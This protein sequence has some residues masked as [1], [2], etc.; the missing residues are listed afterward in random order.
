[1]K[2]GNFKM[3]LK[4][5]KEKGG[6]KMQLNEK[7]KDIQ[8][9]YSKQRGITLIALVV[10]IVVLLI[11]AGVSINAVFGQDGIIKRAKYAQ[12]KMDQATQNDLDSINELNNWI[13]GKIN[14]TTGGT[15]E[16]Q[17][18]SLLAMYQKAQ[19]DGCDNADGTCSDATHLHIG[20][21]VDYKNPT[22]GTAD[23]TS[24][25]SGVYGNDSNGNATVNITQTYTLS[26]TK[27]NVK[28]R[29]LGIDSETGGLKLIAADPIERDANSSLSVV[30]ETAGNDP[31]LYLKGAEA[32]WY[33]P[34]A[35]N[36]ISSMYLNSA[37]AT[38]SRSVTMDD[39]NE[40]TGVTE[41]K[42]AEV[43]VLHTMSGVQQY[44]TSFSF[45]K[46]QYTPKLWLEIGKKADATKAITVDG[47]GE[48]KGVTG[49]VYCVNSTNTK[50]SSVK[51]TNTRK[52][53]LIFKN[54]DTKLYWLSSHGVVADSEVAEFGLA[55]VG[56]SD[57]GAFAGTIGN[58]FS[59]T[60]DEGYDGLAVRPVVILKPDVMATDVA[61]IADQA[62]TWTY[63]APTSSEDG[64]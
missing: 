20:D 10:T 61:K 6:I 60:G 7:L 64:N 21:Y 35:M 25:E 12:N 23:V 63:V 50:I 38:K 49:Y 15:V 24:A 11:L 56:F 4:K 34:D 40:I 5:A 9:N 62:S 55:H 48:E 26:T 57:D 45:D 30:S 14:G 33:G 29:V 28:W 8:N 59:S 37:Y 43:N 18:G 17:E 44:G 2:R 32:Y 19:K 3:N 58:L 53:D 54:V 13:D 47:D 36:K 46:K 39:V 52:Y 31:Y 22:S 41:D 1:M 51:M 16:G 27:N 42:I